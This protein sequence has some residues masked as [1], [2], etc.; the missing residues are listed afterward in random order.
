M[1]NYEV[2]A[3]IISPSSNF[4]VLSALLSSLKLC[5]NVPISFDSVSEPQNFLN[6]I[7]HPGSQIAMDREMQSIYDNHTWDLVLCLQDIILLRSGK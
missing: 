1:N 7:V 5:F 2:G 4:L 3:I 6:V